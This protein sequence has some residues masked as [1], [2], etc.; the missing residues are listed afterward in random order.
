MFR[1]PFLSFLMAAISFSASSGPIP[2]DVQWKA[3]GDALLILGRYSDAMFFYDKNIQELKIAT[4]SSVTFFPFFPGMKIRKPTVTRRTGSDNDFKVEFH[5]NF[6][7]MI[8]GKVEYRDVFV[9]VHLNNLNLNYT[10]EPIGEILPRTSVRDKHPST[11]SKLPDNL[12]ADLKAL[13]LFANDP[14]VRTPDTG[15]SVLLQKTPSAFT[16]PDLGERSF[17]ALKEVIFAYVSNP[18]KGLPKLISFMD[19]AD[20]LSELQFVRPRTRKVETLGA[21]VQQAAT[22]TP[23]VVP[24]KMDTI[25]HHALLTLTDST[26]AFSDEDLQTNPFSWHK[27]AVENFS[28][29]MDNNTKNNQREDSKK[30]NEI[31]FTWLNPQDDGTPKRYRYSLIKPRPHAKTQCRLSF[32]DAVADDE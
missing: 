28:D 19:E 16:D 1:T 31:F 17:Y 22:I 10:V 8:S 32:A 12:M 23:V 18:T 13:L 21:S 15:A 30:Q 3:F 25:L 2:N 4:R 6:T 9:V 11:Q 27:Q 14:R 26:A 24:I 20:K 29:T 7:Q 5:I